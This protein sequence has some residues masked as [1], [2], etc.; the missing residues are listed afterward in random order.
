MSSTAM[1]G[2]RK[3]T[4]LNSSHQLISYA[5][6]CLKKKK[7]HLDLARVNATLERLNTVELPP[8]EAGIKAKS[9]AVMIAHVAFPALEP[10]PFFFNNTATTE[11]TPL[12]LQHPL[13]I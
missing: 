4:R 13:P 8:F 10:Y 11:I 6:F 5:V 1:T 9:G 3:S 7:S 12:S 2:D